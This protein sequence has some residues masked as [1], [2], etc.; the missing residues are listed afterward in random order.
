MNHEIIFRPAVPGDA[1]RLSF[2]FQHVYI[3]TYGTEGIT[4]E[5]AN[6]MSRRF[7]PE[8]IEGLI[9]ADPGLLTVATYKDHII[10]AAE[11]IR[12][13]TSPV[14][15]VR[16]PELSKLYVLERFCG[17]GVGYGLLR[18]VERRAREQAATQ[19]WL[20]V[21]ALNPRAIAFYKR[22]GYRDIGQNW[23][24][25]EVNRYENRVML[26]DL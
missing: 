14:G 6:F 8:R 5:F 20:E 4:T 24:Q 17:K 13:A 16:A 23:F 2:L 7:A 18:E 26:K 11:M 21:Y 22:Q 1:L 3:D 19:L 25:M 9:A 12:D 15:D 10:G